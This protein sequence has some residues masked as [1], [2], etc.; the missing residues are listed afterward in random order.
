MKTTEGKNKTWQNKLARV[1]KKVFCREGFLK[2]ITYELN[3]EQ[4]N[5]IY[6][7]DTV[8]KLDKTR[9]E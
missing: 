8:D 2:E 5:S 1:G 3:L 9:T 6:Q 4:W 7:A